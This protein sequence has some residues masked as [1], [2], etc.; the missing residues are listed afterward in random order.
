MSNINKIKVSG[1]TYSIQDENACKVVELTQAQYDDLPTTAKTSNSLFVITDAEAGDLSNYYTKS[2]TSG[3]TEISTA[4]ASKADTLVSG[5]N[6]KTINGE[7]ILG[8]GN[9]TI[10]GG[11]GGGKA[12]EA[13]RGISIT[14][15]ETADTVSFNLP[16]SGGTNALGP[17]ENAI[18]IGENA[19]ASSVCSF[20]MG[21]S[22]LADGYRSFAGGVRSRAR[23]ETTFAYG[24]YVDSLQFCETAFGRYNASNKV[25]STF[26]DSGNTLFGVGNGT[27]DGLSNYKRHNALEI[28]QNGDIYIADTNDT[29]TTEYYE[30]PMIKLQDALGGGGGSITID[31]SLD[32]GS[33]NPVANSAI[34][35]AI[36]QTARFYG[37][38]SDGYLVSISSID[39]GNAISIDGMKIKTLENSVQQ[40]SVGGWI[41]TST[42]NGKKAVSSSSSNTKDFS[43][44]ETSAITT[45]VTSSST[46]TQVPSAKAVYDIV[47]NIETLL[48]KI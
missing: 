36:N 26:G 29:S 8:E 6:I 21:T 41:Y 19:S 44:V 17:V 38:A 23:G 10:Q 31:Q 5:T 11:S 45:S 35:N 20:A 37:Y 32:S 4:L 3:A 48:S 27:G 33:T 40:T 42:I 15:G 7:S 34:T 47:G 46:D 16:I 25:N 43:L 22:T 18:K 30:K 12:I 14:T 24:S 28:R 1:T 9:I 39:D 13:G 2:E